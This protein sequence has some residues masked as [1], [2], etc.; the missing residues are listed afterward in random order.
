MK[1]KVYLFKLQLWQYDP[2]EYILV[3][4]KDEDEARE[5]GSKK[6]FYNS[7]EQSKPKDLE[8]VTYF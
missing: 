2:A 3:Y 4:A 5:K 1:Q 8:L 7:G 6:L